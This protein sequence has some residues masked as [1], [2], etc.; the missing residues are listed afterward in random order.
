M[1]SNSKRN[2]RRSKKIY[3]PTQREIKEACEK[4]RAGLSEKELAKRAGAVK[5][6]HWTPDI[7]DMSVIRE[8]MRDMFTN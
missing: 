6:S 8:I 3:I 2:N 1:T 7:V 4:I 5:Q